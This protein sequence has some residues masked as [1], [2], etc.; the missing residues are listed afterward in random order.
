MIDQIADHEE[1]PHYARKD[2]AVVRTIEENIREKYGSELDRIVEAYT[3]RE[4]SIRT[5]KG[6]LHDGISGQYR[7]NPQ[8]TSVS[9]VPKNNVTK[10]ESNVKYVDRGRRFLSN[11]M[12]EGPV[13][14]SR[15]G[16]PK[17]AALPAIHRILL[18]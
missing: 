14:R 18:L 8:A 6:T 4:V 5:K 9:K 10:G 2:Q 11:T 17:K 3:K 7:I 13:Y 15:P 1:F 12:K 16:P